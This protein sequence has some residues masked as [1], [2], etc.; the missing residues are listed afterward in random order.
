M[1]P[2]RAPVY[3]SG[4]VGYVFHHHDD[5][6]DGA[7]DDDDGGGDGEADVGIRHLIA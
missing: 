4:A 7:G 5:S 6:C 2:N 1:Y 3:V